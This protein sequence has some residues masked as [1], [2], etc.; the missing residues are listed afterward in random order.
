MEEI[1]TYPSAT[2]R[3]MLISQI[4]EALK[5][6]QHV[7]ISGDTIS[8]R[9]LLD[10][11]IT[12]S[13]GKATIRARHEEDFTIQIL[14]NIAFPTSDKMTIEHTM[15]QVLQ[16]FGWPQTSNGGLVAFYFGKLLKELM[17]DRVLPVF[18]FEHPEVMKNKSFQLLQILSEYTIDRKPVGMPS[19]ICQT[20]KYAM[21]S[22]LRS[23]AFPV[24]LYGVGITHY[25]LM[26]IIEEVCPGKSS[27][28]MGDVLCWFE[29]FHTTEEMKAK[30]KE[31]FVYKEKLGL[32]E[33][34]MEVVD[35]MRND[36][37]KK[38]TYAKKN[39]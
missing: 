8:V 36:R 14:T 26:G 22:P 19:I 27:V 1:L 39:D 3:P 24:E 9:K 29:K 28:F 13:G 7:E 33:I 17:Y 18:L 16:G 25:E 21:S 38:R 5:N 20:E 35:Q 4:Q 30:I 15:R 32:K 6:R 10:E 12:Y 31:L 34:N 23:T 11:L 37:D 2:T